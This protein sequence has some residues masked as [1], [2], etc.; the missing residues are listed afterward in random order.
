MDLSAAAHI[1]LRRIN[2]A[3][4]VQPHVDAA[5]NLAGA[6]R[7]V[8]LFDDFHLEL[9]VLL[10]SGWCPHGEILRIELEADVDN[11]GIGRQ[12][13]SCFLGESAASG[14]DDLR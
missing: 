5:H 1:V 6:A 14:F 8:V 12:H 9:H 2:V 13:G 4:G 10:E 3:A 11:P 7:G